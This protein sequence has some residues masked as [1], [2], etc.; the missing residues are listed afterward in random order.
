M[1][2]VA[3]AVA[4]KKKTSK[5][6]YILIPL[7]LILGVGGAVAWDMFRA[8]ME[9]EQQGKGGDPQLGLGDGPMGTLK[10]RKS[11]ELKS[12]EVLV[13]PAPAPVTDAEELTGLGKKK[14]TA[15]PKVYPP[16]ERAWRAVK[17]DFDRLEAR[18]ETTARKYRI[19]ILAMEGRKDS[20][21]ESSFVKE[22]SALEEVLKGEL[23]KAE[24]Q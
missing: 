3:L 5:A 11:R 6:L 2:E 9:A 8:E 7:L 12:K 14:K 13:A 10:E 21:P 1:D 15:A 20:T 4:P 24:N 16:A 22:A 17:G 23:A 19:Q 18:N